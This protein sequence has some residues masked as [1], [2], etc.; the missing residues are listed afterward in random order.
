MQE[1]ALAR[2]TDRQGHSNTHAQSLECRWGEVDSYK[3]SEAPFVGELLVAS[4]DLTPELLAEG[5]SPPSWTL[6]TVLTVSSFDC[7]LALFQRPAEK[8]IS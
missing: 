6:S 7:L 5:V 3:E 1:A 2:Q 4:S 8:L